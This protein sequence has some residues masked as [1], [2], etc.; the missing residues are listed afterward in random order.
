L[1]TK[2]LNTSFSVPRLIRQAHATLPCSAA[3]VALKRQYAAIVQVYLQEL[4]AVH[5]IQVIRDQRLT[6]VK[7][8][9]L[10]KHAFGV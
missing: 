5:V 6:V 8:Q 1:E 10:K 7:L 3:A 9:L 4:A 2:E